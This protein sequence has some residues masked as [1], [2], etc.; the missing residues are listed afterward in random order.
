MAMEIRQDLSAIIKRLFDEGYRFDFFQAVSLLEKLY[1]D[2]PSPGE[3]G[4]LNEEKIRFRP[5]PGMGFPPTDICQIQRVQ[6]RHGAEKVEMV[7]S[8]MGLYGSASPLPNHINQLIATD[9]DGTLPLRAFLDIFNHRFYS[10]FYRSW[11]KY[12]YHLQFTSEGA[13][14]FS[15]YML[16]LLGLG[17]PKLADLVGV[18]STR[19]IAY[20][21]IIGHRVHC[22][23]GLRGLLSDY[24]DNVLVDIQEFI[25]RWVTMPEQ[26]C[27]GSPQPLPSLP[28]PPGEGLGERS[29]TP[30]SGW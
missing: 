15:Q 28:S 21:G 30:Q 17:T 16:S 13:D 2:S 26:T 9:E 29:S 23:E 22:K 3:V 14:A 4:P 12:R 10:L 6:D 20:A 8:F 25:P 7:L 11:K 18:P 1:C 27:L 5:H 24:F 19:L